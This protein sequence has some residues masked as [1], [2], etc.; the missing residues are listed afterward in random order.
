MNKNIN[1]K[2]V[3]LIVS[4]IVLALVAIGTAFWLYQL[5]SKPVAPN[6]PESKPKASEP[7]RANCTGGSISWTLAQAA[8]AT[9]NNPSAPTNTPTPTPTRAIGGVPTNTPTPTPT[10]TPTATIAPTATPTSGSGSG[11]TGAQTTPT[12]T[13][14]ASGST[15]GTETLPNAGVSWPILA[16]VSTGAL[17]L[18][19]GIL[20]A[21]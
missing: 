13:I 7:S 5:Q 4:T 21:L 14:K 2:T 19:I 20:L 1:A 12:P 8:Q 16:A 15:T 9:D 18:F 17:V 11:S 10:R 6:V 3:I